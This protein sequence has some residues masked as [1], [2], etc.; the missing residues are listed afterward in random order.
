MLNR[1]HIRIKVMQIVY[2]FRGSESDD[3]RIQERGLLKSMDSMYDLYL[4]LMSLIVEVNHRALDY[5]EKSQKKHLA[6]K[7][8]I[9]PNKKFIKNEVLKLLRQNTHFKEQLEKRK[10]DNWKLDGEYVDIIFRDLLASDI[11]KSYM[12]NELSSFDED[13][14]FV[15]DFFKKIIAPNEKLHEYLEDKNITWIDDLAVVNTAIAKLLRKIKQEPSSYYF[16]PKLIKDAEDKEFALD[17]LKK[18]IL[19]STLFSKE[20]EEKTQNW[21]KDR[22]ANIDF[23]LLKMA[24]CEFQKFPSIPTKVSINEYLE[25]AKEY[26]TPKSSVFING[27]LDKIVKEY[28]L[29]GTLNKSARG[30]M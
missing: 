20:V 7:E 1:R 28:E 26:S 30:M 17:L 16:V 13:K 21:D 8:E 22:I 10:I 14:Q 27:I 5:L 4:L 12:S 11:Y 2:A 18:T 15:L 9:N 24:I 23:V 3:L 19:N 6:T 25:I 29:K